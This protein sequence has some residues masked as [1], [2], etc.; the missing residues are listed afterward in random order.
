MKIPYE[1]APLGLE[2]TVEISAELSACTAPGQ[3]LIRS[4]FVFFHAIS[5]ELQ[6]LMPIWH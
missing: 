6:I 3:A 5:R 2:K 1:L 4:I